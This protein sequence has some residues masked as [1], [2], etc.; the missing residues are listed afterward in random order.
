MTS[1]FQDATLTGTGY[2]GRFAPSP[3][4]PLHA[5]SLL[6][7][8]GS[9]LLARQAGGEWLVRIEDLDPP[10]EIPGMA[11]QHL[12]AL[13]RFGMTSDRPV[14]WQST[15]GDAYADALER[16][17]ASEDAYP[18]RCSRADLE[19]TGG[20]HRAC[21]ASPSGTMPGW[22]L[23][24]PAQRISVIDRIRGDISQDLA[25]EVGDVVLRRADGPWAYQLAVVV[26]DGAQGI[27]DIVRGADLLDSTPR[28]AWLQRRLGLPTPSYAHLPL[29]RLRDGRKLSKSEDA[30]PVDPADPLPSLR[31][32]WAA[33]GQHPGGMDGTAHSG[34]ALARAL[35]EFEPLRIPSQD[36]VL[37][38]Q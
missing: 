11:A 32:A 24:M 15:R 29:L 19:A 14:L 8:L 9:W 25:A 21:V 33:L 27:T 7:A 12:E 36:R 17:V 37:P 38:A 31:R 20:I 34:R 5:G 1:D 35:A 6:A 22:R 28:Q 18:C 16:L 2:R 3:S 30:A 26:D 13:A 4:G 10:R 23:R